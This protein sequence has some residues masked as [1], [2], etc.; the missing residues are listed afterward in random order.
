VC[1]F[2]KDESSC[3]LTS[4]DNTADSTTKKGSWDFVDGHGVI[5]DNTLRS[6]LSVEC[7]GNTVALIS[8]YC[9]V[10]GALKYH[11]TQFQTTGCTGLAGGWLLILMTYRL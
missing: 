6:G 9:P 3:L 8:H 2:E 4:V 10:P 7:F 5:S 1:T 11:P